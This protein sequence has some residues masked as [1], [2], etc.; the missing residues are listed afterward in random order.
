MS[1]PSRPRLDAIPRLLFLGRNDEMFAKG[2][3]IL[4]DVWPDVVSKIPRARLVFAGGGT[5]LPKLIEL[6]RASSAAGNID[7]LGFR[8]DSEMEIVWQDA[9]AFAMLSYVEGFGLVFAE[10]MRHGVPILASN[11]DASQEVNIDGV[12]G[13]NVARADRNGI[14]DRIAVLLGESGARRSDGRR[15]ARTLARE[16]SLLPLPEAVAKRR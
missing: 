15:R 5:H 11:D 10:A 13:F 2:Q 7:I 16:F 3:D 14:V 1:P 4:I 9:T 8:S 12:T 6:V